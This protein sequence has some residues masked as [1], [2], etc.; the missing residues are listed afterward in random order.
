MVENICNRTAADL[1][2][3]APKVCPSLSLVD[4]VFF[5]KK[6]ILKKTINSIQ[7]VTWH[8]NGSI[9]MQIRAHQGN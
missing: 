7:I 8:P 5:L 6:K 3:V 1:G 9:S 4:L 2:K